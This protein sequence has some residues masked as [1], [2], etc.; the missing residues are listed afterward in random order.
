MMLEIDGP[1][2]HTHIHVRLFKLPPIRDT[3]S[4]DEPTI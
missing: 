3:R 2:G 1:V 4:I